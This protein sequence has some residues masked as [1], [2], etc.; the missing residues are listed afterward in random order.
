MSSSESSSPGPG[1]GSQGGVAL[2]VDDE[3]SNRVILKA[4]LKRLNYRVVEACDGVEALKAFVSHQP[5]IVFLDVMMPGMDGYEAAS[6]IKTLAG[7][8]F[9][10][11]IFLTA[12]TDD[13]ALA[14]C[15]EAGGDDFLTKPFNHTI[16]GAKIQALERI[17]GLHQEVN[18]LYGRMRHEEEL[19]EQVFRTAV[20]AGNVAIDLI[21]HRLQGAD[22]F[23][24]DL[25]L[26]A[27]A[28]AGDLHLLL[29]DFTGHGLSAALGA[30]PT[31]EVFRSMTHK[32]FGPEQIL[33]AINRKLYSLL[34]T[35][36]FLAAA[37][38]RLPPS[39]DRIQICNCGLP[40]GLVLT[41][42]DHCVR[43]RVDSTL[44]PLGIT[45]D[46]DFSEGLRY[47]P[48]AQGDRV[49]L[50][51]DG[52]TEALN[53]EGELFGTQRFH[54][55][56]ADSTGVPGVLDNINLALDRFCGRAPQSDDISL[57]ELPCL[58][59]LFPTS[60]PQ[61][62]N[63]SGLGME[64]SRDSADEGQTQWQMALSLSGDRLRRIDPVPLII[65]QLQELDGNEQSSGTLFTVLTELYIN[66][67]DHGILKLDSA[68][69]ADEE[70]FGRYFAERERRLSALV[71]GN[72]RFEL[73][74]RLK[75][76]SRFLHIR[77]EDDGPGFDVNATFAAAERQEKDPGRL[78][79]RG[80]ALLRNLCLAVD[81]NEVG[82]G[83]HAVFPL[84]D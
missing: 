16:L 48:V 76:K 14:R 27:R 32:G 23:S 45:E 54:Q 38:V 11:I 17:R 4:L 72:I 31:A 51:S 83:V 7:D 39:L 65:N 47:L 55:A 79:G 75:G 44:L 59:E 77:V 22:I 49:L 61:A 15:V 67:L 64:R 46:Q 6:R 58:P 84:K 56:I 63:R 80:I 13:S 40:E 3:L 10:P 5:D 18:S 68:Q 78:H 70:G 2:V 24:G 33:G 9:V 1:S 36:M 25:L 71:K 29:G 30:M 62:R 73:E 74:C 41:G 28:P 52:V 69:K 26:S 12:L 37:F 42:L 66:A 20:L 81:Y 43:H 8:V 35:G 57:V 50:A 60:K 34:P 82:N 19:A 53:S 21:P